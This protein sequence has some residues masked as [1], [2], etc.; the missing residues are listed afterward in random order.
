[1]SAVEVLTF[2]ETMAVL[3]AEEPGPLRLARSLRLSLA[4]AESTVAIGLARLGHAV[5]WAGRVGAD[6]FGDLVLDRLRAEGVDVSSVRRDDGAP[7]GLLVREQRTADL[8]RVH[9]YRAGSAGS[10]LAIDD[11]R[12]A[13]DDG[14]RVLLLSGITPALSDTAREATLEA[15]RHAADRDWT[16]CLDVNYRSRLWSAEGAADILG[17]LADLATIVVGDE[18]ELALVGGVEALVA[19]G[20]REVVVKQ[21]DKG[22][23]LIIDGATWSVPARP[24]TVVD[25]VGAGDAFVAGYLS[26]LLDGIEPAARLARASTVAA[27]AV[28]CVGDWEGLPTRAEL[29]QPP[30]PPN[31]TL[32]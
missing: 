1:M 8:A 30:P 5:R 4:G 11:L 10:R 26:G 3:R 31:T 16:V 2:G 12:P 17:P 19:R 20:T 18:A 21:G 25:V 15:A 14:T 13:L 32:R 23:E 22:A 6:E 28:S 24:V 7:T 9:Y 27:F 29:T